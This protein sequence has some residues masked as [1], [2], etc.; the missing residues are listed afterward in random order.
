MKQVSI[1]DLT[2]EERTLYK[3]IQW[4]GAEWLRWSDEKRL[5]MLEDVGQL[6]ESLFER[7][8]I[9]QVRLDY[10]VKPEMNIGGRGKSRKQVFESNGTTGTTILRHPHFIPYLWYFINGPRLPES[11]VDGFCRIVEEDRGTS[12][13]V[14]DQVS[15]FVRKEVRSRSFDYDAPMSSRSWRSRLADPI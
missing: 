14:L 13:M 6:A 3:S 2:A 9:E 8:A 10:F 7:K 4:E 1:V 11:V 15:K 5:K 12:G